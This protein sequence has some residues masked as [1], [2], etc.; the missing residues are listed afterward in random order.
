MADAEVDRLLAAATR[1]LPHS[2]EAERAVLGAI[3][4]NNRAYDRTSGILRADHFALSEHG[5]VWDAIGKAIAADRTAD[6]L[7]LREYL[8]GVYEEPVAQLIGIADHAVTPMVAGDYALLI[9]DMAVRRQIIAQAEEIIASA[10]EPGDR[11]ADEIVEGAIATLSTTL[12]EAGMGAT[13]VSAAELA[14]EPDA[15][16]R[17]LL[18]GDWL[19][20]GYAALVYGGKSVGKTW[21]ATSVACTLAGDAPVCLGWRNRQPGSHVLY[22]DGEMGR[23]DIQRV[24]RKLGTAPAELTFLTPDSGAVEPIDIALRAGQLAVERHISEKTKLVVL[25]NLLTLSSVP[26]GGR[27][28]LDEIAHWKH[29]QRWIVRLRT[30]GVAVILIHHAG[31]SGSQLGTVARTTIFNAVIKLASAADNDAQGKTDITVEFEALRGAKKPQNIHASL[32]DT[33]DGLQWTWRSASGQIAEDIVE[34]T[35]I[36]MTVAQIAA[37]LGCAISTVHRAMHAAG[38]SQKKS[39]GGRRRGAGMRPDE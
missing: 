37:E 18:L 36:G 10:Y 4:V 28:Y 9:R 6:P 2:V 26:S 1:R 22:V 8:L 13:V 20:E 39:W 19:R 25:D 5:A 23:N 12:S 30:R 32:V 11:T 21:F 33:A 38:V 14:A 35:R 3:L 7:T 27:S 15:Q 29:I 31:K 16:D 34:M 24:L 17:P